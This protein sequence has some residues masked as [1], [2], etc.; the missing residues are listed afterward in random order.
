MPV[1][2]S[3]RCDKVPEKECTLSGDK[4][5]LINAVSSDPDFSNSVTVPDGFV[6]AQLRI[7]SPKGTTLYLK[8][9]DDPSRVVTATVPML[10][11]Q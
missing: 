11:A 2:Q 7:P 3:V 1:L 8:L 4:L 5:F 10:S 9:R 6:E